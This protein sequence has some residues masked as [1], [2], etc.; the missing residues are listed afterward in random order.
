MSDQLKTEESDSGKKVRELLA[1]LPIEQREYVKKM[2]LEWTRC[3][4][5]MN[6]AEKEHLR[7]VIVDEDTDLTTMTQREKAAFIKEIKEGAAALASMSELE[8]KAYWHERLCKHAAEEAAGGQKEAIIQ[9]M[10]EWKERYAKMTNAEKEASWQAEELFNKLYEE[11]GKTL[12]PK[13]QEQF[14]VWDNPQAFIQTP[15]TDT[16]KESRKTAA[17]EFAESTMKTHGQLIQAAL[18]H[19]GIILNA[20][21]QVEPLKSYAKIDRYLRTLLGDSYLCPLPLTMRGQ[22]RANGIEKDIHELSFIE[23]M[24]SLA[25]PVAESWVETVLPTLEMV[26]EQRYG[27]PEGTVKTKTITDLCIAL[28]HAIEHD[29]PSKPSVWKMA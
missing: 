13:L 24:E 1:Q 10:N 6:V 8:K 28:E 29:D 15:L 11:I 27:W 18:V 21:L 19:C 7:R 4:E 26:F 3:E 12:V 16:E 2:V 17:R 9:A 23:L 14:K 5:A 22:L 25:L 20:F